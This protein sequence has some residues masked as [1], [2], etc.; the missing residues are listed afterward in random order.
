MTRRALGTLALA[1]TLGCV[2][3][4]PAG[5]ADVSMEAE[6]MTV[7]GQVESDPAASGGAAARIFDGVVQGAVTTAQSSTYL[8]VRARGDDCFGAPSI[9][10]QIDGVERLAGPVR[11]GSYGELGA[12]LSIPAGP[13]H[14]AVAMTNPDAGSIFCRRSAVIDRITIVGQPFSP[15]GWRNARLAKDAPLARNSKAMVAELRS[16]IRSAPRGAGVGTSWYGTPIYVVPPDQPTVRVAGPPDRPDLQAQWDAVPLPPDAR[17]GAGS[18]GSLALWQPATDTYW[19]FWGLTRD[20]RPA[21]WR[22]RYGGRM[23]RLSGNE[24]HFVDPPGRGFGA[25]GSSIMLLSGVQRVEE[26]R[27]GVIDHAVL[28]VAIAGRARDG[29]C[30]PAQ[31]TD[32]GASSRAKRAIPAG[33]RFRLPARFDLKA[34]ARDPAH[35]LSRYALTVALAVQRYGMFVGDV[36]GTDPGFVAEDPTPLGSD[37]Y[38][39]LFEGQAP[40]TSGILRNF[41]WRKL[42]AIAPPRGQGCTDDPDRD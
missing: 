42:Q 21:E 1:L 13:H 15:T 33:A 39:Q 36:S 17:P 19:E 18:D 14:M 29:W 5:A 2:G 4:A 34:Y 38:E 27:R 16:Q 30:W 9:S 3:A 6:G 28:F 25:S 22:A 7:A 32:P 11:T 8:F 10:V 31:R 23:Q 40:N 37:P 26:L 41:P 35:P 24:G 20:G 12:R